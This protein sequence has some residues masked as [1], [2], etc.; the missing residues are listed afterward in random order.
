MSAAWAAGPDPR[1]LQPTSGSGLTQTFTAAF[2]HPDGVNSHYLGY[3]LFLPTPNIVWFTAQGSCLIEYNKISNGMRIVDDAGTGWSAPLEGVP[4]APGT[5][6][7]SNSTCTVNVAGS[8]VNYVGSD[9]LLTVPVTF[10]A[11][12]LTQVLGTFAQGLDV[13]GQWSDMRQFGN[14]IV[15]GA[16]VRP[17]PAVVGLSPTSSAGSSATL[18]A[19]ASHTAGASQIGLF[20]MLISDRVVG[21]TACHVVY[22]AFDD[23]IALIN[24]AG[25]GFAGAGRVA[26]GSAATLANSRCT[27]DVAGSTRSVSAN[28][29]SITYPMTF[30]TANFA[31]IKSVYLNNFDLSGN[32]SH[33]VRSGI[34]SVQ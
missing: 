4:V 16:P 12:G 9:M 32:L 34:Q 7:L 18:T 22:F 26:R 5:A 1:S 2:S 28:S 19:T 25:T 23:T 27:V 30:S 21:G 10:K 31:G 29:V 24:D 8:T 20:H 33:W 13:T 17:G 3:M 15:P 6:P 11:P 14:W